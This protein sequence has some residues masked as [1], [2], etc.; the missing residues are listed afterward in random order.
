MPP[1]AWRRIRCDRHE[2]QV[3]IFVGEFL[4][5]G[6]TTAVG[7]GQLGRIGPVDFRDPLLPVSV[8]GKTQRSGTIVRDATDQFNGEIANPFIVFPERR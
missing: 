6:A 4:P 8:G 1:A 5:S 3:T 2:G 7:R